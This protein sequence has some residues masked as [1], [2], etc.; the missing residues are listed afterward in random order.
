MD[1]ETLDRRNLS[2]PDARA[3]AELL[4]TIWP[5]PG[6]TVEVRMAELMDYWKDYEGPEDEH[7]RLFVIREEDRVIAC[8]SVAPRTVGTS[9]GDMTVQ[10]LARVCTDPAAR[11]RGL[12]QRVV[13]AAFELVDRGPFPFS[14]FQT[15]EKVRPYYE[16][17]G[18]VVATNRIVNSRGDDPT[19]NPFWDIVVMRYPAGPGWPEGEID[20]RGP[21][22]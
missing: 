13:R 10:A 22:W 18:A 12:G 1:V 7:P 5:K 20:L 6:R 8:A 21:G 14:L 9:R 3:V 2:E 4:C 15:S 19:K 16:K 17:L 11:G